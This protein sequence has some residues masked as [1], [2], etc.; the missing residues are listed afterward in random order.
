[1]TTR[2][3]PAGTDHCS[4]GGERG[5]FADS[6]QSPGSL[7]TRTPEHLKKPKPKATK[8]LGYI[9]V[10]LFQ[11]RV[12]I[13]LFLSLNKEGSPEGQTQTGLAF[14]GPSVGHP[15][16]SPCCRDNMALCS[17]ETFL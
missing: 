12:Y 15:S 6:E 2:P 1:M 9:W 3:E 4:E 8:L 17:N 7:G 10:W 16:R 13:V 5:R 11:P 14:P